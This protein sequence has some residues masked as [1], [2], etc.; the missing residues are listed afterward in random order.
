MK[1]FHDLLYGCMDEIQKSSGQVRERL[2]GESGRNK[3]MHNVHL[4]S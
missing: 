3:L 2:R 1:A 4:L